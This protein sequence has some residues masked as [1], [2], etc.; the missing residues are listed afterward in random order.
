MQDSLTRT[1]D[2]AVMRG[3]VLKLLSKLPELAGQFQGQAKGKESFQIALLSRILPGLMPMVT[4]TIG[5]MEEQ[6]LLSYISFIKNTLAILGDPSVS[7]QDFEDF[8]N[9]KIGI[10]DGNSS[11]EHAHTTGSDAA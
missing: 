7:E 10:V 4:A 2:P 9:G 6:R 11:P 8:L 1:M 5:G 3:R